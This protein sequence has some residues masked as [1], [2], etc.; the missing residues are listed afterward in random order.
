MQ[1]L[2]DEDDEAGST[3][4]GHAILPDTVA[5]SRRPT[6]IQPLPLSRPETKDDEDDEDWNW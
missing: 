4:L 1:S 5:V 3:V 2:I 6:P